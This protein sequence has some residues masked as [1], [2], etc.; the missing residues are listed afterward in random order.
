METMKLVAA[1]LLS[2]LLISLICQSVGWLLWYYRRKSGWGLIFVAAGTCVLVLGSI[3]GWTHE[4]RRTREFVHS[5]LDATADIR[6]DSPVLIVVLGTG[7]NSDPELPANSQVSGTFLSRL[8]EGVRIYRSHPQSRLLISIA[9][10][11]GAESKRFFADEMIALLQINATR[12]DI[13]T[14]S[15]STSDEAEEAIR[16]H[17]GEQV[18]VVTSA[19]HMVRAMTIFDDAGLSPIAAPTDYGFT[20]LGSP[21]DKIWP[22]WVPSAGGVAGNHQWLYEQVASLWHATGGD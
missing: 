13:A 20:R 10:N 4:S 12:V 17:R 19:G 6:L 15:K 1:T 8:L 18:I 7:Y 3:S 16:H 2:P 9:G 22:R 14:E 5:P 11:A 21:D